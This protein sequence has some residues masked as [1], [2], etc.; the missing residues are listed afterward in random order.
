MEKSVKSP[1]YGKTA[2]PPYRVV[3]PGKSTVRLTANLPADAGQE[4]DEAARATGFNKLTT[5]VRAIRVF[6]ELLDAERRGGQVIIQEADGS[7]ARLL[8]R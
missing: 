7:R 2:T 6:S 8:L 5:L 1:A 4:L 3:D